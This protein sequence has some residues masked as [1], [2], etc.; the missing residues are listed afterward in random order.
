MTYM[1]C[2]NRVADFAKWKAV[3]GS[4]AEA[5]KDAGLQLAKVWRGLEDPNEAFFLFEVGDMEKARKF[6]SN[7]KAT[8]AAQSSGVLEGEYHFVEDAAGY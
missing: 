4:H 8:E 7:P 1:L 5:H 3:F 2:R 6:I